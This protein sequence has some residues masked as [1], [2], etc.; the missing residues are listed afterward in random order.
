MRAAPTI[1]AG[2]ALASAIDAVPTAKRT[3]ARASMTGRAVAVAPRI[4]DLKR[5]LQA[6]DMPGHIHDIDGLNLTQVA[7]VAL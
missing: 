4:R 2:A 7:M 3:P 1:T 5:R 6:L